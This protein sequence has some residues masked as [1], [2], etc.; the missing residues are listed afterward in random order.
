MTF[1]ISLAF[2]SA[3]VS[4]WF[5]KTVRDACKVS[6]LIV[7]ELPVLSSAPSRQHV[8]CFLPYIPYLTFTYT[9]VL[10]PSFCPLIARSSWCSSLTALHLITSDAFFSLAWAIAEYCGEQ[11]WLTP[12]RNTVQCDDLQQ[13]K[14]EN[15]FTIFYFLTLHFSEIILLCSVYGTTEL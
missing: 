3:T 15:L 10:P 14:T 5:Q 4:Q 1:N 2:L 8:Q 6:F 7:I 13:R 11:K 9:E 12:N